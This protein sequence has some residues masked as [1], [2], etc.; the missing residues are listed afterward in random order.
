MT[1][2]IRR[3]IHGSAGIVVCLAVFCAAR[4][5]VAQ[6]FRAQLNG[7]VTDPS[8]AAVAGATVTATSVQTHQVYHAI[9]SKNGDYF[10]PY[11]LPGAYSVTVSAHG[12]QT[13]TEKNVILQATRTTGLNVQLVVGSVEQSVTVRSLA[14]LLN[15]T[16]ASSVSVISQREVQNLPLDGRQ[17]YTL[18]GTTPGTQFLQTQFGASGYSGTR[19]WDVSNNYTIGGGVQGYQMFTMDG[20]NITAMTGFGSQGD[21]MV[22]PNVDAI[23]EVSVIS[24]DYNARFGHTGGGTVAIVTK[25]GTNQYHGDIYEYFENGALDANTFTNNANGVGRSN[26]I[27]HQYG[28]TFGGPILRNK[29]FFFASF[30][31][32]WEAI[33]FTTVTSVPPAYLRPRISGGTVTSGV[34]FTQSGYSIY[35]P[36]TTTCAAAGGAIGDCPGNAYTRTEFANDTIPAGRI[37]PAAAELLNLFPLPNINTS[38]LVNNYTAT[39]PD[40]YRYY[41]PMFRLDYTT[42]PDTRWYSL[43]QW[44]GGTEFRDVSGFTGPAE[45]GN[46]N[47]S[48][49]DLVFSQDMTHVFSPTLIGDFKLSLSRFTDH[50][51]D[52]PLSTPTPGSIGLNMPDV[53][54]TTSDLLPQITFSEIYPQIV[55]NSV[56]ADVEQN[57]V[58]DADFTKSAGNH[59]LEFGGEFGDYYFSDPGSVGSP[60]GYFEFGTDDTQ[61]NPTQRDEQPGITDGNVLADMLLGYPDSGGVD[62]NDTLAESFPMFSLYGQ[63]NMR[64]SRR[65]TLNIGLRY[66]VE[67]GVTDRYNRLNRGMCITCVNPISNNP[68][69]K[70][71]LANAANIAAWTAAGI[72]PSSLYP[73]RGGIEFTGADGQPDNAYNVDWGNLAP[74]LGFAY[75]INPKTVFRGGFGFVYSYGI[76]AGTQS[77]FSISTPYVASTNGGIT[78]ASSFLNGKPFPNGAEKPAGASLGLETNLGNTQ[79]L[80]F[81]GREI[82]RATVTSLGFQRLLPDHMVLS[83]KYSGNHSRNLRTLGAFVWINQLPLS[84]GYYHLQQ[85]HYNATLASNLT[86]QVPNPYDGVVP[87]S[88]GLGSSPTVSAENLMVALSQFGLVGDYTDPYGKSEYDSLQVKLNKRMYGAGH[89]LSMQVAYTFSKDMQQTHYLNGWP[90]QDPE[91]LDEPT[92]YDRTNIFTWASEWDLPIGRGSRLLSSAHGLLGT[93]INGWRLDWVFNASTGFPESLPNYLWYTSSHSMVPDGGPTSGQ[94]LYNCGSAGPTSCWTSIPNMGQGNLLDQIEYLREPNIPNLDLSAQKN[95]YLGSSEDKHL[96]FRVEAFNFFN[97]PLFPG[98]DTNPNDGPPVRQANGQYTGFGTIPLVQQNFP[99][100]VQLALKYIF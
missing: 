81:P 63:D 54:T 24:N 83:V 53:A 18:L 95:F 34:N 29:L 90:F 55:G 8:G 65:L 30:E 76:E 78:P 79:A 9:T 50:F 92:N 35:D 27:Q 16:S 39:A 7:Q 97:T 51:P 99:R 75:E 37:S 69:L 60:N 33:P 38:S 96:Q 86:Q 70:A 42:S 47:T 45:N 28:G 67:G 12:F 64:V 48:R 23:Q 87:A 56:S 5:A 80:D 77:G 14:P 25:A 62:W 13:A 89:G 85:G 3:W 57:L 91:P 41:Q 1:T 88:S 68:T 82:P 17:V 22:A 36:A 94:W 52:G 11:V 21:W 44:Q 58:F 10:I 71:N 84:D 46:I 72:N 15:L 98:P 43:F 100:R 40:E 6:D 19:G 32:Y 2:L 4:P 31:G 26:T 73:V 66:D 74:R 59:Q 61:Y 49:H 20:T 93:A